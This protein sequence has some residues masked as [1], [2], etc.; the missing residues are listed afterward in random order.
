MNVGGNGEDGG[1]KGSGGLV[2]GCGRYW[3][4]VSLR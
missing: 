2:E 3:F 4:Y 1:G